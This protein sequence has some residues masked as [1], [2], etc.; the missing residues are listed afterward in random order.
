MSGSNGQ[1]EAGAASSFSVLGP[2][3]LTAAVGAVTA[4][5]QVLAFGG[6]VSQIDRAVVGG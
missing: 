6:V 4:L 2:A 1:P 5:L 3:V